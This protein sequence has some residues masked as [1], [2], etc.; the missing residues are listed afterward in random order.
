MKPSSYHQYLWTTQFNSWRRYKRPNIHLEYLRKLTIDRTIIGEVY[1]STTVYYASLW[2]PTSTLPIVII[3]KAIN[4]NKCNVETYV[5]VPLSC[6][7]SENAK[8]NSIAKI[9]VDR[10]NIEEKM[11][12]DGISRDKFS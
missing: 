5:S 10:Q 12:K 1:P 7:I 9:I 11:D 4:A 3:L 8:M 6:N 2:Q